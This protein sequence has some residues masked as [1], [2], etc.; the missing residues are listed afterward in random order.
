MTTNI[1]KSQELDENGVQLMFTKLANG[2]EVMIKDPPTGSGDIQGEGYMIDQ[3]NDGVRYNIKGDY[4]P[5]VDMGGYFNIVKDL[6]DDEKDDEVSFKFFGGTHDEDNPEFARCY[7]I[8]IHFVENTVRLRTEHEHNE[9]GGGP[10]VT[11]EEKSSGTGSILKRWVG[12][13]VISIHD[14]QGDTRKTRIITLVDNDGLR[15]GKPANNWTKIADWTDQGDEYFNKTQEKY[16]DPLQHG[17]PYGKYPYNNGKPQQTIRIDQVKRQDGDIEDKFL[18]CRE[19]NPNE[20][21][22]DLVM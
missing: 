10:Y 3:R 22:S 9:N 4:A 18:W 14:G 1:N 19:I 8:G 2:K 20:P 6:D 12:F 17:P 11:C 15:N 13:R 5:A 7:D 16:D 21:L